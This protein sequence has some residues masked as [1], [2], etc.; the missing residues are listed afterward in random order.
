MQAI[1]LRSE[2]V[3]EDTFQIEDRGEIIGAMRLSLL[4]ITLFPALLSACGTM[5]FTRDTP[6]TEQ[7][8]QRDWTE[9]ETQNP[10]GGILPW[11]SYQERC[12]LGR[13]WT[14]MD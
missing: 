1:L 2:Y 10:Y 11:R 6:Y 3:K 4:I 7:N 5:R 12:M 9:C 14:R 8:L 13:G